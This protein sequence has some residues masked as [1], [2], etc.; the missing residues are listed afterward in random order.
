METLTL[1]VHPIFKLIETDNINEIQTKYLDEENHSPPLWELTNPQ[2]KHQTILHAAA[3]QTNYHL[4]MQIINYLKQQQQLSKEQ[5]TS[6]INKPASKGEV[7]LHYAAFHGD[8][9]L[10][11]LLIDN[12]ADVRIK[13]E[14][15]LSV[16][17]YGSQGDQPNTLIYFH[18]K[19]SMPV[20]EPDKGGSTPLHWAAYLGKELSLSYLLNY[21]WNTPVN[22]NVQDSSG[23]TPLHLTVFKREA[24][25]A[26]RLLQKGA[27]IDVQNENNKTVLEFARDKQAFSIYYMIKQSKRC[28]LCAFKAPIKKL[29]RPYSNIIIVFIMQIVSFV[30]IGIFFN[31]I[32]CCKMSDNNMF[33]TWYFYLYILLTIIYLTIYIHLIFSDSGEPPINIHRNLLNDL[34][35]QKNLQDVCP[36]CLVDIKKTSKHCVICNKCVDNFDHHC[37]WVNNCIGK[38]NYWM[39]ILFL[40]LSVIDVAFMLLSP[41]LLVIYNGNNNSGDSCNCGKDRFLPHSDWIINNLADGD[42]WFGY[43][44]TVLYFLMGLVFLIPVILLFGCHSRNACAK[45]KKAKCCFRN[46]RST[47]SRSSI[48]ELSPVEK[49]L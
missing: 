19:Y 3:A 4:V 1:E 48:N 23:N 45:I 20:N 27:S 5:I 47:V 25:V 39:F 18:L 40:F 38:K 6:F 46:G 32:L 2:E 22:I 13:T 31:P 8:I 24:K 26:K 16:M 11:E 28:Q 43:T 14:S 37:Y 36:V 41:V 42:N 49:L 15:G 21:R 17:H 44:V 34:Q 29:K 35:S 33:T 10:I 30:L 12:G 9:K 7:A